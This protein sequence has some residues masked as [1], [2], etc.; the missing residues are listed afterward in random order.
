MRFD[1][2]LSISFD[3]HESRD[4]GRYPVK[5]AKFLLGLGIATIIAVFHECGIMPESKILL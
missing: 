5:S 4:I 1:M 2:I 3:R